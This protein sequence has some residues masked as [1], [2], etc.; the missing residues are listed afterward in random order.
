MPTRTAQFTAI[1][2]LLAGVVCVLALGIFL[3][4]QSTNLSLV[5]LLFLLSLVGL[6]AG[7]IYSLSRLNRAIKQAQVE[8]EALHLLQTENV[9]ERASA[10]QIANINL[11]MEVVERRAMEAELFRYREHLEE[12][13]AQR[14]AMLEK[15][16]L[17]LQD[18]I[19]QRKQ[20]EHKL[21]E[22][23]ESAQITLASIGDAVITT[24]AKGQ[25]VYLNPV[26]EELIGRQNAQTK[27]RPIA[28]MMQLLN[29]TTSEPVENPVLACLEENAHTVMNN[30]NL[31]VRR[32]GKEIP[33]SDTAAPIRDRTGNTI[34]AVLVF[35][36]VTTERQLTQQLSYQATH[37][38]LTGLLNRQEFERRLNRVLQSAKEA[39]SQHALMF[40]DLDHFKQVNDTS[41]HAAGDE[42]LRRIAAL[43]KPAI[44]Q[45]DSLAR[46][47]GDE[48]GI[49]LERCTIQQAETIANELLQHV[50]TFVLDWPG[51]THKVGL[52]IGLVVIDQNS[53]SLSAILSAADAACYESKRNGRN[54]YSIYA[55]HAFE[56]TNSRAA[57]Q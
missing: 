54:R 3:Y 23:K 33:I 4:Y 24:D 57:P 2:C 35:H 31:L 8:I 1:A 13:V 17:H 14:T 38:A 29:E 5:L 25:V 36:D 41:G 50:D 7:A 12:I 15:T 49:L 51:A 16:N 21:F 42:L 56:V 6:S 32:D 20:V 22:Q 27:G 45:R 52:S 43:F 11:K 30:A 48:F 53:I 55:G 46:L 19:A 9:D 40:L 18:E 26:A 37:D 39:H 10:L 28:E 47:G 34:G 44:R